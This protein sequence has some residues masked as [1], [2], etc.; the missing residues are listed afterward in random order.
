MYSR[1]I[2]IVFVLFSLMSCK[3]NS[4]NSQATIITPIIDGVLDEWEG[5]LFTQKGEK[6]GFG[7]MNDDSTLYIALTTYDRQSIMQILR[8]LTIWIDP[9]SKKNKSFGIQYPIETDMASLMD[10]SN[11]NVDENENFEYFITQRLLQQSSIQYINNGIVQYRDIDNGEGM[12]VKIFYSNGEINYE[13]KIP[14]TDYSTEILEKISIGFESAP[15]QRPSR[16]SDHSSGQSRG[17]R[18]G[19]M[20]GSGMSGAGKGGGQRTGGMQGK[21]N[22]MPESINLWLDIKLN[23]GSI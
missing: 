7:V 6:L 11:R 2:I 19:G 10:I 14:F 22:G 9:N 15:L 4:I 13:L 3:D 20:S 23:T 12:Q 8:G 18:G 1:T 17:G 5:K 21:M 16:S